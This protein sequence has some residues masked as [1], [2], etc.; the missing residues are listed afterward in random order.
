MRNDAISEWEES[1]TEP[2]PEP[3]V[4]WVVTL[5]VVPE[6]PVEPPPLEVPV[7]TVML[8]EPLEK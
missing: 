3:L 6:P 1:L 8:D 5:L 7:P 2:E 4:G